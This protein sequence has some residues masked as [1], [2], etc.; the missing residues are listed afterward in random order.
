MPYVAMKAR[1]PDRQ[2]LFD[3]IW[4]PRHMNP[5]TIMPP[6]GANRIL[7]KSQINKIIDFLYTH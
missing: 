1:F 6:F 2:K 5:H 3:Q 7:D 4:D